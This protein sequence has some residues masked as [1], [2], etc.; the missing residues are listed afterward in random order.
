M[1]RFTKE[2]FPEK[3]CFNAFD[4]DNET[5]LVLN[6][7]FL[8]N[9]SKKYSYT[10]VFCW[11]HS[12]NLLKNDT[13]TSCTSK[14][15]NHIE[16]TLEE[17]KEFVLM[18][19]QFKVPEKYYIKCTNKEQDEV[20][21]K[22]FNKLFDQEINPVSGMINQ[23]I[24]YWNKLI[25]GSFWNV[26]INRVDKSFIELDYDDFVKYVLN[27]EIFNKEDHSQLIKLLND[28]L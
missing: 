23:P 15:S 28:A 21:T 2:T 17:F 16:I 24:Y 11:Y 8:E 7:Y 6:K 19:E 4:V 27:K 3:W 22:Y 18:E 13:W 1:S 25:A 12:D 20:L 5:A 14:D 9:N 26:G 10:A